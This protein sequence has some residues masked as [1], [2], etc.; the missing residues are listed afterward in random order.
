MNAESTAAPANKT[1]IRRTRGD[2]VF[3]ALNLVF[4]LIVLALVLYPLW[5]IVIASVSDPD[6]VMMGKV[7]LLP[8]DP[9]FMGYEAV[10]QHSELWMS[11]MNAIYY[12]VV[13]SAVSV[14]VTLA[15]AYALSRVFPGKGLV[16]FLIVFTMFFNGGL[17]PTFITLR[18]LGL[19]NTRLMMILINCVSVWNLMVAR[20]YIQTTIPN[21]LYESATLDGADHFTYFFRMVLPLSGTILAVLA[22]YY[23][24]AKWNDYFSALVY[25]RDRAKLPLQTI[26]R[27]VLAQLTTS[28]SSDAFFSAYA[29]D[30]KGMT[31]AI[32]KAAVA[33]YCCIVVSTGPAVVLYI[34]MQKFFV[35]GVMIGSLKG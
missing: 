13:G 2:F 22:V 19:Y 28:T 10:F 17:I 8:Y 26:L 12:T 15:A 5:L 25:I 9:S 14:A 16:N 24:V 23:G 33:K 18:G 27:E 1:R 21:E 4:W 32:R 11:Y 7:L 29:N 3:D 34:F 30:T 35:K 31:D 6:A 20:T